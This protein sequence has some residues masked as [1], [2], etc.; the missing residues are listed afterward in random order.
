MSAEFQDLH[1]HQDVAEGDA[2]K[3]RALLRVVK[4]AKAVGA[5]LPR[6]HKPAACNVRALV[7]LTGHSPRE[8]S[9]AACMPGGVWRLEYLFCSSSALCGK[10]TPAVTLHTQRWSKQS[11]EQHHSQVVQGASPKHHAA[12]KAQVHGG[13]DVIQLRRGFQPRRAREADVGELRAAQVS[14]W[15]GVVFDDAPHKAS[16]C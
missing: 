12:T 8:I 4:N 9:P 10:N 7:S 2:A 3:Q 16:I 14:T 5:A 13:K 6:V 15:S 1:L 11:Q